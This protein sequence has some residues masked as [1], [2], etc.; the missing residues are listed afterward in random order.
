MERVGQQIFQ[1]RS[2]YCRVKGLL[3]ESADIEKAGD[4]S[5][6]FFLQSE[7]L[8]KFF[9][10]DVEETVEKLT[11]KMEQVINPEEAT[12]RKD[13]FHKTLSEEAK[14]V[15]DIIFNTPTELVEFVWDCRK[16]QRRDR[17]EGSEG[18]RLSQHHL[19][20]YLRFYGWK[21]LVIESV[22]REIKLFLEKI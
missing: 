22:F 2:S 6:L 15:I 14:E 13:F 4:G 18:Y 17:D 16:S 20:Q 7:N 21:H 9:L 1:R 11:D 3:R 10:A 19:R 8:D 5:W 12:I